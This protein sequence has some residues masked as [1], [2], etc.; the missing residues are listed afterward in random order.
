MKYLILTLFI[1]GVILFVIN[2]KNNLT[3]WLLYIVIE[4]EKNLGSKMGQIKLRQAY[5][6]FIFAYPILSKLI[7][8]NGFSKM[9]DNALIEMKELL[10]SNK[11]L[12]DYVK[13]EG[14]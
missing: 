9:I 7:S 14:K 13:G 1:T 10:S 3:K 5:D 11:A 8:F 2:Q 4:A 12:R 6:E